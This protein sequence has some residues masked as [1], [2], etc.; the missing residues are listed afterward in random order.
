MA[1]WKFYIESEENLV[2]YSEC[3]KKCEKLDDSLWAYRAAYKT[4]IETPPNLIVF[5]K[6]CHLPM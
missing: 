6:T 1:K 3:T 5:G 4:P 2:E